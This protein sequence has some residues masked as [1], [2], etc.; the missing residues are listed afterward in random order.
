MENGL[1][2]SD[3]Q[4][5]FLQDVCKLIGYCKVHEIK[6]TIG[7]AYRTL[8]QQK[9]YVRTGKSK[10]ITSMHLQRLAIDLNF[11][12][13]GKYTK[14]KKDIENI[15]SYWEGLSP[16]NVWGGRWGWDANHFQ[17]SLTKRK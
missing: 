9:E 14:K 2:L 4:Y 15:G 3:I 11:F 7:E 5:L 12:I 6:V 10:T 13:D 1:K 16:F 17:R 8:Y